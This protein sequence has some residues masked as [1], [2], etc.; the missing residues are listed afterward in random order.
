MNINYKPPGKVAAKFHKSDAF[1][2]GLM[3]PVGSGKSSSCCVELL[4]RAL[5]QKPYNGVRRT[6]AVVIRN[7]YP[8]LK[9]TTIKTWQSWFPESMCSF[10]YDAPITATIKLPDIGDGTSLEMEV[11][12]LALDRSTET[13]KLRS[14]EISFAW[15]NEASEVPKE[16]FDML[17]QRVG[18][19]PPKREGGP[20]FTGVIL[21]TNCPDDD[22]WYYKLAEEDRPESWDFF[23]Q[24]GGLL[25]TDEETYEPN[26]D[27]ENVL[28]LP[29]GYSYYLNQIDGKTDDWINV[30]VL[31]NYGTT[32][33][34]KPVYPEWKDKVHASDEEIEPI[35]GRSI[36][37]GWDFGLTP[38]AVVCQ[39]SARGQLII[40]EEFIA[41]DMGIREFAADVVKPTLIDKYSNCRWVSVGD[42]AGS[43]RA[44]TD[45]RTCF[46]ELFEIGI[47]TE[48]ADTN[49]FLPRRE[50]VAF[51]MNRMVDGGAGFILNP[52]CNMLRKGFNGRYRYQ[53]LQLAG[54]ARYKDR[55][56]KDIYSHIQDALQYAC[57]RMRAGSERTKVRKVV[58]KS[59]RGWT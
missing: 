58:N 55:P 52:S 3:G 8:E 43:S 4:S 57:L 25:K 7:T 37:I 49:D 17:T 16:I 31:A 32:A 59:A 54:T 27:A 19:F 28:N 26:P 23:R 21:D 34:G 22:N 18:R 14:L 56:V 30:F 6:R 35:T 46:Q 15:I 53:R 9:S 48:P 24:P 5:R 20:T 38:A 44:Q 40:L 50:S 11:W 36:I 13:G 10:K 45:T 1:V 41:E 12:F 47:A 39:M 29:N 42:P 51:F 2:R 33:D